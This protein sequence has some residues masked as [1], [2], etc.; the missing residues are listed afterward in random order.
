M[1]GEKFKVNV[2]M[3]GGVHEFFP[4]NTWVCSESEV[5]D[6]VRNV[7]AGRSGNGIARIEVVLDQAHPANC[8][9]Q[10]PLEYSASLPPPPLPPACPIC[11]CR[12]SVPPLPGTSGRRCVKCCDIRDDKPDP[13]DGRWGIDFLDDNDSDS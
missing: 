8:V 2:Y 9:G 13:G 6:C 3:L 12:E 10:S 1:S 5:S 4:V 11:G 7:L